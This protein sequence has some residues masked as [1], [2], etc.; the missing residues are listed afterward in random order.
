MEEEWLEGAWLTDDEEDDGFDFDFVEGE[1][2]EERGWEAP[3][4]NSDSSYSIT[5]DGVSKVAPDCSPPPTRGRTKGA[6]KPCLA[7]NNYDKDMWEV[8]EQDIKTVTMF[9]KFNKTSYT[10]PFARANKALYLLDTEIIA[11]DM[12]RQ[13]VCT[14]SRKCNTRFTISDFENHRLAYLQAPSEVAATN[15]LSKCMS[16]GKCKTQLHSHCMHCTPF[17]IF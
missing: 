16:K 6:T 8:K 4:A 1:H 10:V 11:H 15:Y 13:D 17:L 9:N 7:G 2:T 5:K 14:C 3:V 12:V